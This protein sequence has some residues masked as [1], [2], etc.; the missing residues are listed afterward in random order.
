MAFKWQ[1]INLCRGLL[2]AQRWFCYLFIHIHLQHFKCL[3][4]LFHTGSLTL[5]RLLGTPGWPLQWLGNSVSPRR[6]LQHLHPRKWP[7]LSSC[8]IGNRIW[9]K[10]NKISLKDGQSNLLVVAS[11]LWPPSKLTLLFMAIFCNTETLIYRYDHIYTCVSQCY[12]I[13]P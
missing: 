13:L 7:A 4:H 9:F 11:Q 12:K 6:W 1:G 2:L 10:K 5:W 3:Q 8:Q